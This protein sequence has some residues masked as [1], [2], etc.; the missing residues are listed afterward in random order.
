M[1]FIANITVSGGDLRHAGENYVLTCSVTGGEATEDT[2]YRWLNN[3]VPLSGETSA[4]LSFTPLRQTY[5][6][7]NG[8]Y[9]CEAI[10]SGTIVR[11]ERFT[12]SV[13][14]NN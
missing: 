10:R 2:A 9:V 14:G 13:I 1:S 5:P 7:S 11:S 12:I 3:N 6:S 4:T 8:Q